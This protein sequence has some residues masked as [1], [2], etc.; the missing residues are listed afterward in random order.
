MTW[1]RAWGYVAV[2]V[3]LSSFHAFTSRQT[4]PQ[5]GGGQ[6]APVGATPVPFLAAKPGDID[7]VEVEMS[8][9]Y[10][11]LKR[12]GTRWEV[13]RPAGREVSGDLI[14]ALLTAVLEAPEVEVVGSTDDR[15]AD[16]GMEAP[17]AELRLKQ[18]GR[19]SL[20][21]RLGALN[22]ARTA[23]YASGSGSRQV[24]LLGLN[25]RYYLDLV[26]ETLFRSS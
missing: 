13:V 7:E 26:A 19:P 14:A 17:T 3:A 1:R 11:H 4:A 6:T 22:P 23:V 16:F 10:A 5:S 2:F 25:I 20:T 21:I 8:G 18:S 12:L 24:V 15:T 9:Q